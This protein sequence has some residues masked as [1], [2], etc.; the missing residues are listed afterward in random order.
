MSQGSNCRVDG[1][2]SIAVRL[3]IGD[4]R[5]IRPVPGTWPCRSV[6]RRHPPRGGLCRALRAF[7][8]CCSWRRRCIRLV[9]KCLD[10]LIHAGDVSGPGQRGRRI[11][12]RAVR[13]S[14]RQ[15]LRTRP[16]YGSA[17]PGSGRPRRARP[18]RPGRLRP[19][20]DCSLSFCSLERDRQ[21]SADQ[22]QRR[23]VQREELGRA[24]GRLADE[25]DE[26]PAALFELKTK[27]GGGVF[28]FV[29]RVEFHFA[30]A[31]A[32]QRQC[33]GIG[34]PGRGQDGRK[35]EPVVTGLEAARYCRRRCWRPPGYP[36]RCP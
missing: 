26:C 3:R 23:L 16:E 36:D 20:T 15:S 5:P 13:T 31:E 4:R 21:K 29:G 9:A 10:R 18:T 22:G 27:E 19:R 32:G 17:R 25:S 33:R 7:A 30:V 35:A 1:L 11:G 8:G 2:Q 28:A 14:R 34:K 24:P 6:G 12:R